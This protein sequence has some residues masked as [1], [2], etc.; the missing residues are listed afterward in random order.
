M[1]PLTGNEDYIESHA[2]VGEAQFEWVASDSAP[3]T[4]K[5]RI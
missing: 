1:G 4:T 2:D 5:A 3:I